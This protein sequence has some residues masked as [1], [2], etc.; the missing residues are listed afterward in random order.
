MDESRDLHHESR[1][2]NDPPVFLFASDS[3]QKNQDRYKLFSVNNSALNS[4]DS[5]SKSPSE[6]KLER[7][8]YMSNLT[9]KTARKI[10]ESYKNKAEI[11]EMDE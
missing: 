11:I 6:L 5:P 4:N 2:S 9:K 1:L 3:P 8:Q 10:V 7:S